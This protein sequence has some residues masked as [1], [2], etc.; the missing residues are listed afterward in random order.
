MIRLC[1]LEDEIWIAELIRNMLQKHFSDIEVVGIAHNG[2][3]ALDLLRSEKIDILLADINVPILNGLQTIQEAIQEGI[4]CEYIIITGYKEFEYIHT[5]MQYG[6]TDYLL[7]PIDEN[8]FSN[9]IKKL[10]DKIC[11]KNQEQKFYANSQHVLKEAFFYECF[12]NKLTTSEMA[13]KYGITLYA[14]CYNYAVVKF[15]HTFLPHVT[16]NS[17]ALGTVM[18]ESNRLF[19][20]LIAPQCLYSLAYSQGSF[21]YLFFNYDSDFEFILQSSLSKFFSDVQ[22]ISSKQSM[23]CYMA[24]GKSVHEFK[25]IR[26]ALIGAIDALN[27]QNPSSLGKITSPHSKK[28][29]EEANLPFHFAEKDIN[30]FKKALI[31][32]D[33]TDF[34]HFIKSTFTQFSYERQLIETETLPAMEYANIFFYMFSRVI[35]SLSHVHEEMQDNAINMLQN[36]ST[37]TELCASI[38]QIACQIKNDFQ[39]SYNANSKNHIIR[40]VLTYID[41]HLSESLFLEDIAKMLYLNPAYLSTLFKQETSRNYREYVIQCRLDKA[42]ELLR[43]SNEKIGQI[44]IAVGY[45]DAKHFGKIFKKEV[46]ITPKEYRAIYQ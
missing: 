35:E 10:H 43:N 12:H 7:K 40:Q 14:G 37:L 42:K 5:A 25:N 38:T 6:V 19:E 22:T 33:P 30:I 2:I 46:G 18:A 24:T 34:I 11:F 8:N 28:F 36:C 9:T 4:I 29:V 45:G 32:Q 13:E 31:A 15:V 17:A 20:Q 21:L 16:L 39:K 3:K 26:S 1:I 44:A 41:E 23:T 27:L